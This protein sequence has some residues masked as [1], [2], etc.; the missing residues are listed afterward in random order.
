[1]YLIYISKEPKAVVDLQTDLS[2]LHICIS[3]THLNVKRLRHNIVAWSHSP[4]YQQFG[5]VDECLQEIETQ[6]QL[7]KTQ[8]DASRQE[9]R[10]T[11]TENLRLFQQCGQENHPV[12]SSDV[13]TQI[14]I[15]LEKRNRFKTFIG[16]T[17]QLKNRANVNIS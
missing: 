6:L 3:S 8:M 11:I 10:T 14:S 12:A 1:M 15:A 7:R 16:L 13:K 4:L 9:V 5:K 17:H 2:V